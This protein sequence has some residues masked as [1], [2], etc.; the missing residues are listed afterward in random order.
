VGQSFSVRITL[1][2]L[3]LLAPVVSA[4]SPEPTAET[5]PL[6][7]ILVF[8]YSSAP[9]VILIKATAET[10][11]IFARSGIRLAWTYCPLRPS[12]ASQ[13]ACQSEPAPGEIRVR[14]LGGHLNNTFRDSVFG[15]A[16]AP[17]FAT[18]YYDSAQLLVKT[19]TDSDSTLPIVLGCLI[20]HEIGHLLLGE[21]QHTAGGIMQARW[22]IH[23]IQQLMKG[24]LQFTSE[25]AMRM[26][27]DSRIRTRQ[28]R[29]KVSPPRTWSTLN[30]YLSPRNAG[31]QW[32]P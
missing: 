23:Q 29:G 12:A 10:S 7:N 19:T 6:L 8:N 17:T 27:I 32:F 1:A 16:N 20:A 24:A 18:V 30:V 15:F 31:E 28:V 4:A 26:Q 25:Q 22:D 5:R 11:Q 3:V 14:V 9:A 2:A 13:V 21:S